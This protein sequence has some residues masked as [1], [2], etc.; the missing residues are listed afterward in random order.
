[1][2]SE[3]K[4][5]RPNAP[6]GVWDKVPQQ[7]LHIPLC[8]SNSSCPNAV[9][10]IGLNPYRKYDSVYQS[11]IRLLT[12]QVLL[13]MNNMHVI[14]E[15][16]KKREILAEIDKAK[17]VFFNNVSHE[18]RTP[19]T[20][21]LGPLEELMRQPSQEIKPQ[22]QASIKTTHRNAIRLLKL[23]NTLLDFSRIESGRQDA[24]FSK[25]DIGVYTKNLVSNFDSVMEKASLKFIVNIQEIAEPVYVNASMWE[26]IVFNLFSNAF[27]YTLEGC[28]TLNLFSENSQLILRVADTGVGIPES[29]LPR[30]FERF[31]RVKGTAGRTYEGTGIGLSLIKELV[32][33][34][35]GSIEVDSTTAKDKAGSTF[36]VKIPTGKEHLSS[37]QLIEV[38]KEV[39]EAIS[40]LY[41]QEAE[42]LIETVTEKVN[43]TEDIGHRPIVLN[44]KPAPQ[45]VSKRASILIVDDNADMRAY[46]K[47]LLEK[48]YNIIVAKNGKE[49]LEKIHKNPLQLILSD[50]MMPV[51]DGIQLLKQIKQNRQ[52]AHIP[53]ILLS[54]RAGEEAKIEGYDIGADDYIVKPFSSKELLARVRAQIKIVELRNELEGN[55]R[56]LFMNAP[57]IICVLSGPEHIYELANQRYM[58]LIGHRNIIG[59][60][61]REALPELEGSGI[62]EILD[63]VYRTGNSFFANERAVTL[64]REN[65]K[66][67]ESIFNFIYQ[68]SRNVDGEINGILVYAIDVTEQVLIR[69][70]IEESEKHLS[71]IL[72]Q[73]NAGIAQTNSEGKFISVNDRYCET[74]GYSKEELLQQTLADI[75]HPDDLQ[76]NLNLFH[77]CESE[78]KDYII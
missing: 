49:A 72:S 11:F 28:V 75:T 31:H 5:R 52:T 18:F 68:A 56:N 3:N 53:V 46:L 32:T 44:G 8:I 70:K 21:M 34:H 23:V 7:I 60:S 65:G 36:T 25:V 29:E 38:N 26:K 22:Y 2:I 24:H 19:L 27:K 42:A 57:A 59:K 45:L 10:T 13:E 73:V 14:E 16:R 51:M 40:N 74:T 77:L 37:K 78:G 55:V 69:K 54:A 47:T 30:M 17:T 6:K 35:G 4:G 12:D 9:L 33:L 71:N 62:Y 66:L 39:Q 76:K 1:V 20:L 43:G 61:I 41:A 63:E 64:E 48:N 58:K 50:I 15:E 67:Q